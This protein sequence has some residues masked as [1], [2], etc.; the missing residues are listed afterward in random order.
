MIDPGALARFVGMPVDF[1]GVFASSST[2]EQD[3]AFIQQLEDTEPA[4]VRAL[5]R[6]G[7]E[8]AR[9]ACSGGLRQ[10]MAIVGRAKPRELLPYFTSK[11]FLG[12]C[13]NGCVTVL[14]YMLQQ[15]FDYTREPCK[16]LLHR[17]AELT[18]DLKKK[19]NVLQALSKI[20]YR[21]NAPA[22]PLGF[23]ALHV[24]VASGSIPTVATIISLGADVNCVADHDVMPLTLAV[25]AAKA[26]A[27][28]KAYEPPHWQSK[29]ASIPTD[30]SL[31][32]LEL[33]AVSSDSMVHLLLKAGAKL[34]WRAD[35]TLRA[36]R[37]KQ[38]KVQAAQSVSHGVSTTSVSTGEVAPV[39]ASGVG[40]AAAGAA[41]ST[42]EVAPGAA[43]GAAA[44]PP[45]GLARHT[46]GSAGAAPVQPSAGM[47]SLVEAYK[48][49][50][51]QGTAAAPK[52]GK[53]STAGLSDSPMM[54][55]SFSS[56]SGGSGAATAT[57]TPKEIAPKT[58]HP[59]AVQEHADGSLTFS[60]E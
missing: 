8:L 52:A 30:I 25:A 31:E 23:T 53:P 55:F 15:G 36:Q 40:G 20:G 43:A 32:D 48:Q 56:T 35:G 44:A 50:K 3:L 9:L 47:L 42:G 57:H 24:A 2:F 5:V 39:A 45:A 38:Q 28:G 17:V 1:H 60:T 12:A 11:M 18:L 29:S 33:P 37:A 27:D 22:S 58:P 13:F 54:L 7:Q 4:Y 26:H 34:T 10:I 6:Q 16:F 19:S 21:P 49:R 51:A 14:R 46:G 41:V 59:P